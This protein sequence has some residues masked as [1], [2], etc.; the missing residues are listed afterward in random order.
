VCTRVSELCNNNSFVT[1]V[2]AW[3]DCLIIELNQ[4]L[5]VM[6]IYFVGHVMLT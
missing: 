2:Y 6:Y 3:L 4:A 5:H 1:D